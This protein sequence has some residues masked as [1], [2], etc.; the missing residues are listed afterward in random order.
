MAS[1]ESEST[2]LAVRVHPRSAR[3]RYE[4]DQDG[5]LHVWVTA[6]AVDGAANKALLKYLADELSVPVSRIVLVSG[7]T[8]RSKRIRIPLSSARLESFLKR[9]YEGLPS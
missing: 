8:S 6:P 3:N 1:R 4:W 7:E 9:A 5:V 2:L